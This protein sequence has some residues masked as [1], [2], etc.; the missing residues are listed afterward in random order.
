MGDPELLDALEDEEFE[1]LLDVADVGHLSLEGVDF[2]LQR[3][4]LPLE[5]VVLR[6]LLV[7]ALY[8]PSHLPPVLLVLLALEPLYRLL[9]LPN[10][11]VLVPQHT[12]EVA[13]LLA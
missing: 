5:A 13:G 10:A 4:Y 3:V 12:L 1:V 8:V 9:Q 11:L 2:V 7:V 6:L